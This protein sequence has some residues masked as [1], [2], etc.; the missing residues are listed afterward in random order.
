LK[1]FNW[2]FL[3]ILLLGAAVGVMFAI[4]IPD[5]QE[6]LGFLSGTVTGALLV[7]GYQ[8]WPKR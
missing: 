8:R 1:D 4:Y 7:H 3:F 6:L 2:R 5:S